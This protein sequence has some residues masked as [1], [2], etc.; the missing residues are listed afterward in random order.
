MLYHQMYQC[1]EVEQ[2][3]PHILQIF[4]KFK[5][6]GRQIRE[7]TKK[8][9]EN[10]EDLKKMEEV[11]GH[12]NTQEYSSIPQNTQEPQNIHRFYCSL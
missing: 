11:A 5:D 10:I 2:D 6:F 12:R 9:C 8:F 1:G 4:T 7:L 3:F